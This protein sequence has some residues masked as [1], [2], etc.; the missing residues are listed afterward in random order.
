MP[1][2]FTRKK[3]CSLEA[4][5]PSRSHRG[6]PAP[7][8]GDPQS[9]RSPVRHRQEMDTAPGFKPGTGV[10]SLCRPGVTG[11]R[12][13]RDGRP[14]GAAAVLSHGPDSAKPR[15]TTPPRTA[16]SP[17]EV[18][19]VPPACPRRGD[20]RGPK[21]PGRVGSGPVRANRGSAAAAAD[22]PGSAAKGLFR[23]LRAAPGKVPA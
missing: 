15:R 7:L 16:A 1:S 21:G 14:R 23:R 12:E 22:R 11:A 4:A 3:R 9:H 6:S 5:E 13:P 20:R 19:M 8:P 2:G 17:A 18:I 10:V